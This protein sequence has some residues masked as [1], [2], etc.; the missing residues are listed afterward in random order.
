MHRNLKVVGVTLVA[1]FALG[2]VA[3]SSA[4]AAEGVFTPGAFP[5][6]LTVSQVTGTKAKFTVGSSS[7]RTVECSV[8]HLDSTTTISNLTTST[9]ALGTEFSGCI[10]SPGGGPA[11]ISSVG[12]DISITLTEKLTTSTGKGGGGLSGT[13]CDLK[14][15]VSSTAGSKLCEYTFPNQT[16][17]GFTTWT[18]VASTPKDD[19]VWS[20]GST[21]MSVNVLS[22]TLA[23][24]G[25]AAGN[26]TIGKFDG[27]LTITAE[28]AGTP[29][30]LTI[31]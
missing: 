15:V 28:V 20:L 25:A 1:L 16:S 30:S 31:S 8:V 7:A 3:A 9:V 22:G 21:Q 17:T 13:S 10:T 18:S 19:V 24:C 6:T 11:T 14:I 4:F 2:A 12:C 26:S 29:T 27:E 5:A 23:A